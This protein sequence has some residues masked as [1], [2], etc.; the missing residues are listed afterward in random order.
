V[1]ASVHYK[2]DPKSPLP[3]LVVLTG[4]KDDI[5][6]YNDPAAKAGEQQIS[7]AAFMQGWKKRMIVIRPA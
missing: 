6:Y 1:I 5:V 4:I 7:K 2:F 3:H